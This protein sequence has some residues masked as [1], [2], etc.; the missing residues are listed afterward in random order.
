MNSLFDRV[1]QIAPTQH[2]KDFINN[3]KAIFIDDS[4]AERKEIEDSLHIPVFGVDMISGL[5]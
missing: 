1:I 3:K 5:L 4:F 2:K